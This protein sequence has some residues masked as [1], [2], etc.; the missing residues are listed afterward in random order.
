MNNSESHELN[1]LI[2]AAG[3]GTRMRSDLAKVLHL[4]DGRPLINHVCRTA[5]ALAVKLRISRQAAAKHLQQLSLV[6]LTSSQRGG[7]CACVGTRPRACKRWNRCARM[8]S[9]PCL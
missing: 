5:T 9:Q 7:S 2:L 8:A 4:L 1:V 3:L 6:G